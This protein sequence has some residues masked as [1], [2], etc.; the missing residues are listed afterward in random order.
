[1]TISNEQVEIY[2]VLSTEQFNKDMKFYI[3][4]RGYKKITDDIQDIL[5]N[6]EKGIF[7]GDLIANLK[8]S[9]DGKTYKVRAV[10]SNTKQGKS[11]GYRII[12]YVESEEKIVFLITIYSKKDDD[13]IPT[14][15]EIAELIKKFCFK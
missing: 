12:Y 2:E 15:S 4:K 13:R 8:L 5:D 9:S 7:E 11:N 1:M 3:K 10:N 14:D 6:L